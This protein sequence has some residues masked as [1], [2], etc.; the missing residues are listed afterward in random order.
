MNKKI[1]PAC[2]LPRQSRAEV[3]LPTVAR[4]RWVKPSPAKSSEV[5]RFP[6][7][8]I[9]YFYEPTPNQTKSTRRR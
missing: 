2:G 7:K 4:R 1:S 6:E 3:G 5:Q 8:K 9:V